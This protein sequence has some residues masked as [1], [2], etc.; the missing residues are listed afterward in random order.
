MPKTNNAVDSEFVSVGRIL[1]PW[2][3]KGDLKVEIM[4]DFPERFAPGRR[5]YVDKQPLTIE[6]SRPHKEN[7]VVKLTTIDSREAGEKFRGRLLEIPHSEVYPLPEGEY[8]RFELMDLEV[9]TT[10]GEPLGEIVDILVTGSND[11]LVVRK[12]GSEVLI[13]AIEDVI[14]FVDIEKGRVVIELIS[15]L[16]ER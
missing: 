15:G 3:T 13:P 4:T 7:L 10:E 6:R 8:Y 12:E 16:L 5:V 2:G 14:K 9:W 1:A 11:V